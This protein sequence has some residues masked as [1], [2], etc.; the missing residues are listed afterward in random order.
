VDVEFAATFQSLPGPLINAFYNLP[1]DVAQQTLGRPLAGGATFKVVNLI[2]PGTM[3]GPRLNQLD[4]RFSKLLNVGRARAR[5][6]IDLYNA[7]NVSTVTALSSAYVN[8]QT[9]Q[10]I[11]PA[12]F[13]KLG[14]QLDF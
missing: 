7:L 3:F 4:L 2:E 5:V 10:G 8:W 1:N 12:R 14:V 6:G 9:P 11:L 13:V